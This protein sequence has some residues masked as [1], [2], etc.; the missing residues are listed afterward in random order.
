[1]GREEEGIKQYSPFETL[2]LRIYNRYQ[3]IEVCNSSCTI[4]CA[5]TETD[6]ITWPKKHAEQFANS[7]YFVKYILQVSK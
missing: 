7:S 6:V 3:L 1:M 4:Y 2:F 5:R